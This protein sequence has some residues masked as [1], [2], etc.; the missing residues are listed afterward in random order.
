MEGFTYTDIFATK[1]IEYLIIVGFFLVLVPFWMLLTKKQAPQAEIKT[2]PKVLTSGTVNM[3]QGIFFSR[4]HTWAYLEKQ[5]EAKVGL[6]DLL[7]HLTGKVNIVLFKNRG[8]VIKKGEPL[9]QVHYNG[10]NLQVLAPVTGEILKSNNLIL[11]NPSVIKDDPYQQGWIYALKPLNWKTDIDSCF[12]AED[13]TNW[14]V[15]ELHRVKEFLAVASSRMVTEPAQLVMQDGGE[16]TEKVL[17]LFPQEVW[18][19][20]QENFLS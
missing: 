18:K 5:G 11:R 19:D 12:L 14:A 15:D 17:T 7:L 20:F 2:S 9:A 4:Y 6:D 8:E 10:N 1:G 16:I 3:P 13:A